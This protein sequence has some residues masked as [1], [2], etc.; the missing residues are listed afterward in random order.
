MK[1]AEFLA[2]L[3]LED[4]WRRACFWWFRFGYAAG[5][6]TTDAAYERG[7]ADAMTEWFATRDAAI[8]DVFPDSAPARARLAKAMRRA[9]D[10]CRADADHQWRA[11]IIRARNTP[12][13]TRTPAQRAAVHLDPG[14]SHG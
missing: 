4:R 7:R 5:A 10:G 13:H 1:P 2:V 12:D 8:A 9:D 11:F 6:A 14:H 3:D